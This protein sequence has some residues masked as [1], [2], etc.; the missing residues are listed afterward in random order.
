MSCNWDGPPNERNIRHILGCEECK[1]RWPLI[2]ADPQAAAQ[3]LAG[4]HR[5]RSPS[6]LMYWCYEQQ[7][8]E[9]PQ[10]GEGTA[11]FAVEVPSGDV[12]EG[13]QTAINRAI[14]DA[15]QEGYQQ[16]KTDATNNRGSTA[17]GIQHDGDVPWP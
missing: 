6:G 12:A 15:W 17:A 11:P 14:H 9:A 3:A 4:A 5:H 10:G 16:G 1:E 7:P 8:H 2:A 13:F